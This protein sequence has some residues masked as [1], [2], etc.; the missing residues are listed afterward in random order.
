MADETDGRKAIEN[1][2][3][4]TWFNSKY[5]EGICSELFEKWQRS[6]TFVQVGIALTASG[7]A[8]A[9]WQLWENPKMKAVWTLLSGFISLL[10][11][12]HKAFGVTNK[13][14]DWSESSKTYRIIKNQL[15]VLKFE[16]NTSYDE[17]NADKILKKLSGIKST[18]AEEDSNVPSKD[19]WLTRSLENRVELSLYQSKQKTNF[20]KE[21]RK[22]YEKYK[23]IQ[24]KGE[25]KR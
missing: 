12:C 8:I 23:E 7:S 10:A 3:F 13:V 24:G 17:K 20:E 25:N 21:L 16:I 19:F 22:S 4:L 18:Y 11:I 14:K 15:E 2:A 5:Q 9:G 6:D 1:D